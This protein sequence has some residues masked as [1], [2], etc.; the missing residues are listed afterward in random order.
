MPDRILT[1]RVQRI[2]PHTPE[3]SSFELVHPWGRPLPGYTAGAHIDVHTPG[4]FKRQYSLARAASGGGPVHSYLIGVKHEPHG[5]GGSAALHAQVHEGEL[6]AIS[7]PR[8]SFPL[9]SQ[10]SHHL[11]LAGG[12]GLTPLLAMAQELA[13]RA[14]DFSL[15]VFARSRAQLGFA[16]DLAALGPRVRL[17][18]DDT[19]SPEKI[20]LPGLLAER[21]HHGE[22]GT[23]IYLCGPSGFMHAARL[24]A[25]GAGWPD[26]AVH[27]EYFAAPDP[28]AG[29]ARS[30]AFE[31]Q[32]GRSGQRVAVRADQSAVEALREVG[33]EVPTSC[34]QGLCGS[35]VVRWQTGAEGG[36]PEHRDFCLSASERL[37]QMAL[38]CSRGRGGPLVIDA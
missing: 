23:H 13:A 11:L 1:V 3:I 5:R 29:G 19:A 8:N 4:G 2:T 10:A 37:G 21:A 38:C 26:E 28:L 22:D 7:V 20:D 12:I 18:F 16:D 32:L 36:E 31:L 14:A 24:A 15:C 34:E 6:L 25:A 17:H 9:R 33:I 30:E 35:C 27:A